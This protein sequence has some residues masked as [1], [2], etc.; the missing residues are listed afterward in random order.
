MLLTGCRVLVGVIDE[1]AT[2]VLLVVVSW[3]A[4]RG[5][6]FVELEKVCAYGRNN[7]I[8]QSS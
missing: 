5:S 1:V 2:W 6:S 8:S 7:R 3:F 4:P